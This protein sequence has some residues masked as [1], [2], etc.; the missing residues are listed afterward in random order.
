MEIIDIITAIS[1][2]GVLVVIAAIFFTQNNRNLKQAEEDR[3][4]IRAILENDKIRVEAMLQE[5]RTN[6]TDILRELAKSSEN[7]AKSNENMAKSLELLQKANE[8]IEINLDEHRK[9][10]RDYINEARLK[11]KEKGDK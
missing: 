7:L 2:F 1:N 8:R 3:E 5:E 10:T 6:N 4:Q 11:M 9:T